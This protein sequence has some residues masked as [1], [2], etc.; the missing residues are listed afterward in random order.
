VAVATPAHLATELEAQRIGARTATWHSVLVQAF[1][2]AM[3]FAVTAADLGELWVALEATTIITAFLVGQRRT[4]TAVEAAW[5]YVVICSTGIALALLGTF[6]L[7]FAARHAP[8]TPGLELAAL[9]S[10]AS[11]LDPGVTRIAV[12]LL[13]LGFGAK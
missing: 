13:I 11:G 4:R 12:V 7:N 2:A 5:K 6:L 3:A 9:T 10:A 1:L 8:G